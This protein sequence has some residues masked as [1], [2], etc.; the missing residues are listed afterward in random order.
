LP[1]LDRYLA[2][3]ILL[4]F[5]AGL[6]FLTQVLLATQLL[7]NARL[8]FG[9]GV[10]LLDVAEVVV[11]LLPRVVAYTLPIAFLLG[12]VLGVGRLAEDR[13]VVALGAAGVSTARL[14]RVPLAMSLVLAAV[15]LWLTADLEPRSLAAAREL[16]IDV[17]K[18]N[19]RN[20]VRPGTFYDQIPGTT[21]YAERVRG[22][23]WE[24]VLISDRSDPDAPVLALAREGRL[25]SVGAGEEMQLVLR[26]G[27]LHR[28]SPDDDGY[29]LAAFQGA[30]VVLGLGTA[31]SDRGGLAR[32]NTERLEAMAAR[33]RAMRAAGDVRG[34]DR[35]ESS[36]HRRIAAALAVI[37]FAL[38]AVPLGAARRAGRAF[39]VGATVA[40]VIV[41]YLLLKSGQVLA[42]KGALAAPLALQLPTLVLSAAAV[43]LVAIQVRRGPGAVR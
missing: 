30:E 23:R 29:V 14:V 31:L 42:Q 24:N 4:P 43:V 3:E 25:E 11:L 18:R 37:P 17:V 12:A 20:D 38:L 28:W 15:G 8:L 13:E 19:V 32:G 26:G 21:L 33:A 39:G 35:L 6:L 27:E 40:V 9:S 7:A 22:G 34:A 2:K 5:A 1:L 41:H 10:S 36:L 16:V